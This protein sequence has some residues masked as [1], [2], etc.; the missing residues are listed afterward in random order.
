MLTLRSAFLQVF[1]NGLEEYGFMKLKDRQPYFVRLAGDGIIHVITYMEEQSFNP[2]NKKFT[3][4]G[5]VAT[6]YRQSIN[7]TLSPKRN[8]NWLMDNC[9]IYGR[10]HPWNDDPESEFR[11]FRKQIYR[12]SCAAE[13]EQMLKDMQYAFEIT[14]NIMLPVL[15]EVTDIDS[16]IAYHHRIGLLLQLFDDDSFGSSNPNNACNEGFLYVR[17]NNK[18]LFRERMKNAVSEFALCQKAIFERIH[19]DQELHQKVQAELE[20]RRMENTKV[21]RSYGL[22]V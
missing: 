2:R 1:G 10:L 8:G 12:F 14:Q 15:N 3:I 17:T 9:W 6:V 11:K 21:L 16:C 18:E 4:L 5:G 13:E 7:L 20:R 22:K 19:A